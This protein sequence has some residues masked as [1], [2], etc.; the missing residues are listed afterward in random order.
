[1][2]WKEITVVKR[3]VPKVLS[4]PMSTD[5]ASVDLGALGFNEECKS[6]LIS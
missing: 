3:A 5:T 6:R 4:F 2:L 1:M